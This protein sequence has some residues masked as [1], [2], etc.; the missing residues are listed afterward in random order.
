MDSRKPQ[1]LRRLGQVG[2]SMGRAVTLI[3]AVLFIAI[4]LGL[5]VAGLRFYDQARRSAEVAENARLMSALVAEMRDANM[6]TGTVAI[7][8]TLRDA[9]GNPVWQADPPWRDIAAYLVES[10]AVPALYVQPDG[11][12]I[13]DSR[14][15]PVPAYVGT[16]EVDPTGVEMGPGYIIGIH[17]PISVAECTRLA[18]VSD[19]GSGAV[20]HGILQIYLYSGG[21]E[22]GDTD[23]LTEP[24]LGPGEASRRCEAIFGR[25]GVENGLLMFT[26]RP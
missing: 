8:R 18:T 26:F 3:E 24:P 21:G 16:V 1:A 2:R 12:G 11:P 20:G 15:R 14:K 22:A 10:G 19:R 13:F 17:G 25:P 4:A 6:R 5:I 23:H 7:W 9:D